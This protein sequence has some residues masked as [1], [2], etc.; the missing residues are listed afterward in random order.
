ML[1]SPSSLSLRSK[2]RVRFQ[3][4][5]DVRATQFPSTSDSAGI[6]SPITDICTAILTVHQAKGNI[7]FLSDGTGHCRHKLFVVDG[8]SHSTIRVSSLE[9]LLKASTQ[10]MGAPLSRR[11]RLYI[12][13]TLA[14]SVLQLEG[15][16]WLKRRWRSRDIAF[17]QSLEPQPNIEQTSCPGPRATGD[18]TRTFPQK[19]SMC[20]GLAESPYLSWPIA[21]DI[22]KESSTS[23]TSTDPLVRNEAL[24]AL[25]LTLIELSFGHPL[26]EMQQP[27]D[28]D[29]NANELL[30]N[31]K[32]AK[33]L[34]NHVYDESGGNYGDVVRRC[35]FCPFDVRDVSLDNEEVQIAVLDKIVTPLT[36]DLE[37]FSKG[38]RI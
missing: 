30:T 31:L 1:T 5:E 23:A 26:S 22:P 24:F 17:Y 20:S 37:V 13:T 8:E 7:G 19:S 15:T 29:E 6:Q 18:L 21:S 9:Q 2:R 25:G 3:S 36:Q 34:L 28:L 32:T 10:I 12:A 11:D 4:S 27:E 35:L 38:V 33:R 14:S 16:S